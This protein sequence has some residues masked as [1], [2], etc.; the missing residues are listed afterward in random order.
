MHKKRPFYG[1]ENTKKRVGQLLQKK[2][3][4]SMGSIIYPRLTNMRFSTGFRL[5]SKQWIDSLKE[6]RAADDRSDGDRD[7]AG[8]GL[9]E[10]A[11]SV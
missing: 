5:K 2:L 11:P 7:V 3:P 6:A 8:P 4:K 10:Q 1:N 9:P